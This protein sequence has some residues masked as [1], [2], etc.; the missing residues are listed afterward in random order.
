MD[1]ALYIRVIETVVECSVRCM[2]DNL[3]KTGTKQNIG[4]ASGPHTDRHLT[5]AEVMSSCREHVEY[6]LLT[7]ASCTC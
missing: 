5:R 4:V 3:G 6:L 7:E 1:L 2:F